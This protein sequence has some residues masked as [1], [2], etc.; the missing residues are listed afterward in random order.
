MVFAMHV[1]R[2]GTL[3]AGNPSVPGS[4]Q[5]SSL[6]YFHHDQLGSIAAVSDGITGAV[7]ERLA[8]PL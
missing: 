8:H 3:A 5:T 4:T 1:T 6:R 7:I 2:S